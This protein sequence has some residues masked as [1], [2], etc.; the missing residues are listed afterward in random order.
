MGEKSFTSETSPKKTLNNQINT[1]GSIN[2]K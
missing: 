1:E 2:E